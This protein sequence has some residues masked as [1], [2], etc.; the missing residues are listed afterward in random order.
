MVCITTDVEI[1]RMFAGLHP[2]GTARRGGDVY[3]V[4]PD[5]PAEEDPDYIGN[6]EK[7]VRCR[8]ALILGIVATGVRRSR[9]A[10]LIVG[11]LP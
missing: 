4:D 7:S 2:S 5:G 6:T 10:P 9:Y 8:S 3:R 1:A 11:M